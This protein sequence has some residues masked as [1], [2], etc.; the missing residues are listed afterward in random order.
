MSNSTFPGI[1]DYGVDFD[2]PLPLFSKEWNYLSC[3]VTLFGLIANITL[4]LAIRQNHELRK[5]N[6]SLF[7]LALAFT[8]GGWSTSMC[9]NVSCYDPKPWREFQSW[10]KRMYSTR[11][12][13]PF[14][15]IN[16]NF[17]TSLSSRRTLYGNNEKQ[18]NPKRNN[19][20]KYIS[21]LLLWFCFCCFTSTRIWI[22]RS[23]RSEH[24]LLRKGWGKYYLL[25][26]E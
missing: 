4:A 9:H 25:W 17:I 8:D 26:Y 11:V 23:P 24:V 10:K 18:K 5:Q 15:C 16:F 13:H 6:T 7:I 19:Q 22:L 12:L 2:G 14:L 3:C 1:S 21:R 20:A